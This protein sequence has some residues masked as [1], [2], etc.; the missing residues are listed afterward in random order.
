MLRRSLF[1][2]LLILCTLGATAQEGLGDMDFGLGLS[3]GAQSFPDPNAAGTITYQS[4]SMTP[5]LALGKFGIGLE[6]TLNYR[7]T[8]GDGNDFEI[9]AE[10]WIPD[11]E[12][13]FLELYLPKLRYVRWGLKGDPL[14]VKLGSFEDGILGNGFI[15]GGYAN[16]QYLPGRRI[17]GMSLDVDGQLFGF[18]YV[19]IETFAGNL[20]AFDLIGGRLF[21]RPLAGTGI[22][23]F[24][25]LQI[26]GTAVADLDPFYFAD[27]ESQ[28]SNI[29]NLPTATTAEVPNVFIW[30]VDMRLPILSNP[31]ISLAAFGDFVMQRENSGWMVGAGGRL[32]GIMT[33]GAQLRGLGENFIPVYFDSAYDLYRPL[34]YATYSGNP[35]FAIGSYLGWFATAGFVLFDELFTFNAALDGPFEVATETFKQPHLNASIVVGEGLL[36]GFSFEASYDKKGIGSWEDLISPTDSVIGARL[37]YRIESAVISLVY[38]LQYNPYPDPGDDPWTITSGVE[39]AITLF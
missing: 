30:G 36:G 9:R 28:I 33:Y 38:D 15:L 2:G 23:V 1:V 19:G 22:P 8:G 6:V 17:F 25:N 39:S 14:Y 26:G 16:T 27:K 34:K 11:A 31:V 10:D 32:F 5:D 35:N 21:V 4:L 12:T 24:E 20:A 7:F 29:P 3:I 18:P 37:N 13:N